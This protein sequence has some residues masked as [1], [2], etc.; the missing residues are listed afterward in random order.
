MIEY[1]TLMHKGNCD[2]Y[3]DNIFMNFGSTV[4]VLIIYNG[5][6][7]LPLNEDEKTRVSTYITGC[8]GIPFQE[9]SAKL[10]EYLPEGTAYMLIHI[11]D[12]LINIER[13]GQVYASIIKNGEIK[14]L[15][16]GPFSIED[17][18]RVVCGTA[19]FFRY[20]SQPAILSD[21][22]TAESSEEWMDNLVCRISERNQLSE[23]NL[24]AVTLIVRKDSDTKI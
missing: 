3:T 5:E 21:A 20:L 16:N 15:P 9:V 2:E 10:K 13:H 6:N 7:E 12:S 4:T 8:R 22:I 23:G 19:E 1:Y 18:D 17:D 11:N 14:L 24:T